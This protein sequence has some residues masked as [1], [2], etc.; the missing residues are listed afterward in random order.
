MEVL[1]FAIFTHDRQLLPLGLLAGARNVAIEGPRFE[2]E[3]RADGF[4]E[5]R[6]KIWL[7][8]SQQ[9]L[10]MSMIADGFRQLRDADSEIFR[11]A[12]PAQRPFEERRFVASLLGVSYR[13][14]CSYPRKKARVETCMWGARLV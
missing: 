13:Q 9:P 3:M 14:S 10:E 6:T 8:R 11:Q 4:V 2:A 5:V 7:S 12:V 1:E